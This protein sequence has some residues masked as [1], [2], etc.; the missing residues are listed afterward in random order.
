MMDEWI[1]VKVKVNLRRIESCIEEFG[2]DEFTTVDVIRKYSGCFCSNLETPPGYSFNAQFGK[3]LKENAPRLR[4][5]EIKSHRS[6]NDDHDH[7]TNT[8]WWRVCK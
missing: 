3:L 2:S 1:D 6:I 7:P 8:S 5:T 4:I